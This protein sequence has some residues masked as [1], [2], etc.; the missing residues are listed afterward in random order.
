[1]ECTCNPNYTENLNTPNIAVQASIGKKVRGPIW[2]HSKAKGRGLLHMVE[3]L[4]SKW[5]TEFK[6]STE[7]NRVLSPNSVKSGA[8]A[9]TTEV[10]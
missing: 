4:P 6:S 2:K 10:W 5:K 8:S 9:S 1:V 7:R 3:C